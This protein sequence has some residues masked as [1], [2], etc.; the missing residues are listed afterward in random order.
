MTCDHLNL[1]ISRSVL[2]EKRGDGEKRMSRM[3]DFYTET[4]QERSGAHNPAVAGWLRTK[5]LPAGL[6]TE[7]KPQ[8]ELR[9]PVLPLLWVDGGPRALRKPVAGPG[10]RPGSEGVLKGR[11]LSDTTAHQGLPGIPGTV[12]APTFTFQT[13]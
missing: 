11:L 5:P 2:E 9:C 1:F 6:K 10:G 4:S 3:R 12:R 13:S 7:R 8:R